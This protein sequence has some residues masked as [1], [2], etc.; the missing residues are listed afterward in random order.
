[1]EAPMLSRSIVAGAALLA[2]SSPAIHAESLPETLRDFS[3]QAES[4]L[5]DEA[6]RAAE[7]LLPM[8]ETLMER[9]PIVI[10]NLPDYEMPEILPNGDIIIRRKRTLPP[11]NPDA[12]PLSKDGIKT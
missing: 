8:I 12:P 7:R 1:M 11:I 2:V 6:R 4:L 5:S 9:L 3:E 10:D